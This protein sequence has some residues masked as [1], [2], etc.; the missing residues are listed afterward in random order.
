MPP[1]GTPIS[2]V[3][4]DIPEV[5]RWTLRDGRAIRAHFS[6]DTSAMPEVLDVG[7]RDRRRGLWRGGG[8]L[9]TN[10]AEEL[11]EEAARAGD[12]PAVRLDEMTIYTSGTTGKPKGA[13]PTHGNLRA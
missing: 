2:G 6:I 13:V 10:F 3:E 11:A 1:C 4:F 8:P 12:R 9:V 5:N 7:L